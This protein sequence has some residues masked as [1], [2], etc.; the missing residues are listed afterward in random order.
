M[1]PKF[2]IT[3]WWHR[4]E[5]QGR[6]STHAHGL[7]YCSNMPDPDYHLGSESSELF[8]RQLAKHWGYYV[9]AEHPDPHKNTLEQ[10]Y[11]SPLSLHLADMKFDFCE[12]ALILTKCYLHAC[13]MSYCQRKNKTTGATVCRF[14][15]PWARS[16]MPYFAKSIGKS[17]Y[18]FHAQRNHPML[19]AY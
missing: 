12:L 15:V 7:Y 9:S 19:N 14:E 5:W 16:D 1:V 13:H 18:R 8:R 2:G 4:Y 10:F 3:D 6:G 11:G 17:Y